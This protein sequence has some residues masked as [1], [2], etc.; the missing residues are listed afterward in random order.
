VEL[1][2]VTFQV[3]PAEIRFGEVVVFKDPFSV[4]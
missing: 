4:V 2:P 3:A 1:I